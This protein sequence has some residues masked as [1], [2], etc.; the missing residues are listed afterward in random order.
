MADE[1]QPVEVNLE[2][3][4]AELDLIPGEPGKAPAAPA[5][6]PAG[7]SVLQKQ[8]AE[9]ELRAENDRKQREETDKVARQREEELVRYRQ[10]HEQA[11][12]EIVDGRYQ[13]IVNTIDAFRRDSELAKRDYATALANGDFNQVADAQTRLARAEA[14]IV[15][16]ENGKAQVEQQIENWKAQQAQQQQQPQQRAMTPS[17]R[18]DTYIGQFS[19]KAQQYLRQH[20]EFATDERLNRRLLRAHG[21]AVDEQGIVPDTEAYY[22]FL[23]DRMAPAVQAPERQRASSYRASPP[24]APVSRQPTSSGGYTGTVT[25]SPAEREAARIAGVTEVEY[26]RQM[27]TAEAAGEITR[28]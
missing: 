19:P 18:F 25:L 26:A 7:V 1:T 21:E 6:K 4:Q 8:L 2:P 17:E 22:R 3:E 23:D 12:G 11:Q 28:H 27:L 15:Q 10:A 9:L 16:L 20:P 24:A 5:P 14:Q 13:T